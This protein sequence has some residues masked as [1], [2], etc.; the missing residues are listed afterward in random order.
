MSNHT[1]RVKLNYPVSVPDQY[2]EYIEQAYEFFHRR[3]GKTIKPSN[4]PYIL[5][6]L[7]KSKRVG[8]A[9]ADVTNITGVSDLPD[10]ISTF[11]DDLD[12]AVEQSEIPDETITW[13]LLRREPAATAGRPF[14][15]QGQEIK[16]RVREEPIKIDSIHI[17]DIYAQSWDNLWQFTVWAKSGSRA[18]EL[19][20][21]FED[22]IIEE[23]VPTL[24]SNGVQQGY[25]MSRTYDT[26]FDKYSRTGLKHRSLNFY[27]RTES[28]HI[29]LTP[30]IQNIRVRPTVEFS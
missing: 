17:A 11:N 7:A 29:V 10:Y 18:D 23:G 8:G 19:V 27:A 9:N 28:Q 1:T 16:R 25:V 15:N 26:S 13:R 6:E 20:E 2:S 24:L 5:F 30:L 14:G 22:F 3:N 21:W 12:I 4:V